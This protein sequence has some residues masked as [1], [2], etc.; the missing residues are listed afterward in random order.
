MARYTT[1]KDYVDEGMGLYYSYAIKSEQERL[2]LGISALLQKVTTYKDGEPISYQ[3]NPMLSIGFVY[4]STNKNPA[5]GFTLSRDVDFTRF[6]IALKS[7]LRNYKSVDQMVET[8]SAIFWENNSYRSCIGRFA[9][10][11]NSDVKRFGISIGLYMSDGQKLKSD[12]II[13]D[14]YS[15]VTVANCI[16]NFNDYRVNFVMNFAMQRVFTKV[17]AEGI[18]NIQVQPT[19]TQIQS[20]M[21]DKIELNE[22]HIQ[23]D[24]DDIIPE[25][26]DQEPSIDINESA[27]PTDVL[28]KINS[29]KTVESA[30]Q[31]ASN[32]NP[33]I[34][35]IEKA[36]ET[37][38]KED[39][40]VLRGLLGDEEPTPKQVEDKNTIEDNPPWDEPPQ[41]MMES[42]TAIVN[43]SIATNHAESGLAQANT[44]DYNAIDIQY[45]EDFQQKVN[46]LLQGG[47]FKSCTIS[48]TPIYFVDWNVL[49]KQ[50]VKGLLKQIVDFNMKQLSYQE[51]LVLLN[52][53]DFDNLTDE[54]IIG[55]FVVSIFVLKLDVPRMNDTEAVKD[56]IMHIQYITDRV[57][58][59]LIPIW[60][61]IV[62]DKQ[63]LAKTCSYNASNKYLQHYID[64]F[65]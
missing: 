30:I 52:M 34:L 40:E 18:Q 61:Q 9:C 36:N 19:T 2:P 48:D 38:A 50:V 33:D 45:T 56:K 57:Q 1:S 54:D 41:M 37:E 12:T 4:D 28:N 13:M 49:D 7:Y 21:P 17:L 39:V 51:K 24:D 59:D 16:I 3:L 11:Y 27:I 29:L 65:K 55:L 22:D 15:F 5:I 6:A 23:V 32:G 44:D 53:E 63:D 64:I 26:P 14:Y 43:D 10:A 25:L 60:K 20:V 46:Q 42:N 47:Y 35:N 58:K 31:P 8:V 62:K